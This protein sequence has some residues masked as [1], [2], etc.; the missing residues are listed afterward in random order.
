MIVKSIKSKF[1]RKKKNEEKVVKFEELKAILKTAVLTDLKSLLV[2]CS[3]A[4]RK[5]IKYANKAFN[6]IYIKNC[7]S[8]FSTVHLLLNFLICSSSLH[9]ITLPKRNHTCSAWWLMLLSLV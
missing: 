4:S 2:L 6:Y 8:H 3:G 7:H 9:V 5:N 1:N